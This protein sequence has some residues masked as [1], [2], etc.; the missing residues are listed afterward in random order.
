MNEFLADNAAVK[1]H[2]NLRVDIEALDDEALVAYAR[3][4][5]K[6]TVL[7]AGYSYNKPSSCSIVHEILL[8]QND[9]IGSMRRRWSIP[10]MNSE[11]WRFIRGLP[12]GRRVIMR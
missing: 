2:F 4:Y 5:A 1:E 6:R 12:T 3:Q 11:S 7:I 10:L 9:H 8:P